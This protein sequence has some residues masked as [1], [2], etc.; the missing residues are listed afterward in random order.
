MPRTVSCVAWPTTQDLLEGLSELRAEH[1]VYDGV[2]SGV[3][4]AQPEEEAEDPIIDAVV[5]DGTDHRHHKEREPTH[6]KS[7]G[8]DGERFC[9]F[10]LSFFLQG[11]VFFSFLFLGFSFL[12]LTE[13]ESALI[14]LAAGT[15]MCDGSIS[16]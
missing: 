4:V 9:C 3:E 13:E 16:K 6:D 14:C 11:N 1:R 8:H 12:F 15:G 2:E 10:F 5:T 7:A